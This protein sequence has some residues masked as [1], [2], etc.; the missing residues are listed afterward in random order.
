[1]EI[2]F[3]SYL[4]SLNDYEQK[5]YEILQVTLKSLSYSFDPIVSVSIVDNEFIHKLNIDYRKIDRPTDVISFAFIDSEKDKEKVLKSKSTYV[6]GDIYISYEKALEQSASYNHSIEREMCF[7][8]TH[9]LLHLLGFDH[10]KKE[11]EEVMFPLQEK[12]LKKIKL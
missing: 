5:F 3:N 7:L 6:L 9:G 2:D 4:D 10:V 1:M 11:D 12:I 8:F